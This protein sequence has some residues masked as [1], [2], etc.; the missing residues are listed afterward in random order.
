VG[1]IQRLAK[2]NEWMYEFDFLEPNFDDSI[3]DESI[4]D[5]Q[6]PLII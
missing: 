6:Q 2:Y 3:F 1:W 5:V 4:V